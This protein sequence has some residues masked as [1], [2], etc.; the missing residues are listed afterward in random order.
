MNL[1][2][3]TPIIAQCCQGQKKRGVELGGDYL[4]NNIFFKKTSLQPVSIIHKDFDS[5]LGYKSLYNVCSTISYPLVLGGDHSIGTSTL[6]SSVKKYGNNLTVIWIDAHADIN[7]MES[8]LTKNR[9][10]TP[11]A[12]ATGLDKCWFYENVD[13]KVSFEKIIYV[14]I[15]DLDP[16]EKE[17]IKK[18]NIKHYTPSQTVDY[19]NN[20]PDS[21]HISFDV[22]ALE[23]KELNSTG[24]TADNGL[25]YLDVKN[26]ISASIAKNNLTG[27][28]V[29]EFNPELGN[30]EKSLNTMNKI[31]L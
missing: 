11:V 16:F 24:T 13:L 19:I 2:K 30:L 27:L 22:D 8:S 17:V 31:F 6:L 3:F 29:V 26:I 14:G 23:P 9:H 1:T 18:Y 10:G 7:T 25:N 12:Y 5:V 4:Y 28:D 21:I 15:R 20:T